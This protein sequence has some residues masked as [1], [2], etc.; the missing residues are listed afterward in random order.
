MSDVDLE[1]GKEYYIDYRVTPTSYGIKFPTPA[2]AN[3]GYA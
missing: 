3:E 2:D 1:V